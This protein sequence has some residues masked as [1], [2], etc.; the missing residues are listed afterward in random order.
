MNRLTAILTAII[1]VALIWGLPFQ[2]AWVGF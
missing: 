2:L 1:L